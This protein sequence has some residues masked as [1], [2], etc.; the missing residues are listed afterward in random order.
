MTNDKSSEVLGATYAMLV[1]T[2]LAV[3]LRF[4]SRHIATKAGF[5]WDDWCSLAAWVSPRNLQPR[6]RTKERLTVLV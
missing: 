2:T 6:I 4:W 3:G 1:I 5:W